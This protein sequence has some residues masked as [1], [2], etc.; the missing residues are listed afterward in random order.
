MTVPPGGVERPTVGLV[1]G[2]GGVV[3][4]AYQVG[5]LAALEREARWDPREADLIVGTSAGSVTG[6][7]IRVGVPA[8]DLAAST[9][10]DPMSS[11]GGA[12]LKRII[13]DDSPLPVP[14]VISLFRLWNPPSLALIGQTVR[15]PLA[16]RPDVAAMTLLPRGRVDIS[17]RA[18]ALHEMVGH[19]WPEGLWI[20]AARRADGGRVV[21]G[22]DG[23]PQAPLA[24]A[25]LASCAIPG[26]FTPIPIDG[27]EYFD[28]GVHSNTNA[29]VLATQH[30]DTVI[31]VS[32]MSASRGRAASPDGLLRWSV[33]RRLERELAHLEAD[34]TTVIR[35]EPGG[36]TRP[37]HGAVGHGRAPGPP[38]GRGGL[39]RD[40]EQALVQPAP[41]RSGRVAPGLRRRLSRGA[42]P[43]P[44]WG[45]ARAAH[46]ENAA[47]QETRHGG[48][49]R[50][51]PHRSP[52]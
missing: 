22:R 11:E 44:G 30:L 18:R 25:V 33:H 29:D 24:S 26:Y 38:G 28:G 50:A 21:F 45:T 32:S 20:C 12:L 48:T 6:A 41:G 7:A 52:S 14:S 36:E 9:C 34:G 42:P 27:V 1:L 49:V 13:P 40:P 51:L 31:V 16:F 15:R 17:E 46:Q 37:R 8:S 19:N 47:H 39:R 5:V 4:Q 23:S 43:P 35:L 10:G 2:A 3:G